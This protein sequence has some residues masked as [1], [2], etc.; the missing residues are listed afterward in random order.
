ML[1]PGLLLLLTF[2]QYPDE[3]ERALIT[4]SPLTFIFRGILRRVQI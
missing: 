3:G 1:R 4:R 2:E